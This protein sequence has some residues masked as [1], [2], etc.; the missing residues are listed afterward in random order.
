ML[1]IM[2]YDVIRYVASHDCSQSIKEVIILFNQ[3]KLGKKSESEI[4]L[5]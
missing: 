1:L 5:L 3:I 4:I 2:K